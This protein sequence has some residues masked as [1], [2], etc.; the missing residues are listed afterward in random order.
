MAG[1]LALVGAGA[2]AGYAVANRI[3]PTGK[4][5]AVVVLVVVVVVVVIVVVVVVV[6]VVAVTVVV[7]IANLHHTPYLLVFLFLFLH[8]VIRAPS[9]CGGF[10]FLS[11][12]SCYGYCRW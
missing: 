3:S 6:V 4:V 9:V 11:G 8:H 1:T 10:P 5:V 12:S 7:V 2:S